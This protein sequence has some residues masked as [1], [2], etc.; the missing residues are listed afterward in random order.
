MEHVWTILAEFG[1]LGLVALGYYWYQKKKIIRNDKVDIY[2]TLKEMTEDMYKFVQKND[3][4]SN[5][6]NIKT[7]TDQLHSNNE[8]QNYVELIKLIENPPENLPEAFMDALPSIHEQV[9]F[10]VKKR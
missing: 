9:I 2:H 1:I 6:S 10:H 5:L 7:Y 3:Q 4:H 8:T